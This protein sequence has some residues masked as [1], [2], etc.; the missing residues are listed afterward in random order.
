MGIKIQQQNLFLFGSNKENLIELLPNI[1][2][3]QC[4]AVVVNQIPAAN[5]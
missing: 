4:V 3:K 5:I 2:S 1:N